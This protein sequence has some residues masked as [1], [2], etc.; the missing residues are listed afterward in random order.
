MNILEIFGCMWYNIHKNSISISSPHSMP[1][2]NLHTVH[3]P[4]SPPSIADCDVGYAKI[5]VSLKIVGID[6]RIF[7]KQMFYFIC[8][9]LW[10]SRRN[11]FVEN[12]YLHLIH[13][14]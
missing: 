5:H 13:V 11:T 9:S 7:E 1:T 12:T 10:L 4:L 3:G 8:N 6:H 2:T 14:S